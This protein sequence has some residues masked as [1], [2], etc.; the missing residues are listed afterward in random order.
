MDGRWPSC[1]RPLA[2][3]FGWRRSVSAAPL[4]VPVYDSLPARVNSGIAQI[5]TW[6]QCIRACIHA[7]MHAH[8]CIQLV[9]WRA[10]HRAARGEKERKREKES[11]RDGGERGKGTGRAPSQQPANAR[12]AGELDLRAKANR[13]RPPIHGERPDWPAHPVL[14][15]PRNPLLP[16]LLVTSTPKRRPPRPT[17]FPARPISAVSS[18]LSL[19]ACMSRLPCR[20]NVPP[21]PAMAL[22][23]TLPA[24]WLGGHASHM[25]IS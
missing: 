15:A 20:C 16:F 17:A 4:P 8:S 12:T 7:C 21:R 11:K 22:A 9:V 6:T 18:T 2:M 13:P 25:L 19:D 14:P 10:G 1:C 24:L 3:T 23:S 5:H